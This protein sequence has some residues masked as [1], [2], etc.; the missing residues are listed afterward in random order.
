MT[1]ELG[2]TRKVAKKLIQQGWKVVPIKKRE[3][4]PRIKEWQN[5]EIKIDDVDEKFHDDITN[6]GILTSPDYFVIDLDMNPWGKLDWKTKT[7]YPWGEVEWDELSESEQKSHKEHKLLYDYEQK[8]GNTNHYDKGNASSLNTYQRWLDEYNNGKPLNTPTSRTGSL[9][10]Q[11]FV[12]LPQGVNLTQSSK[13]I[14]PSID[15]R[16]TGGQVVVSP[17]IHPNGNKYT[18]IIPPDVPIIDCPKWLL[19]KLQ[20]P[21]WRYEF[22]DIDSMIDTWWE[23][24][25]KGSAAKEIAD[26]TSIIGSGSGRKR[27]LCSIAGYWSNKGYSGEDL[28]KKVLP[29]LDRLE[30]DPSDP[31]DEKRVISI[32]RWVDNKNAGKNLKSAKSEAT[33]CLDNLLSSCKEFPLDALP[34]VVQKYVKNKFQQLG[35][36]YDFLGGGILT[37]FS[38]AIGTTYGIQLKDSWKEPAILWH[39]VLAETGSRKTACFKA[40]WEI[41]KDK[42]SKVNEHNRLLEKMFLKEKLLYEKKITQFKDG[43]E[44]EPSD[45]PDPPRKRILKVSDATYESLCHI[46]SANSTGTSVFRAEILGWIEGSSQYS[47]SKIGPRT[48]YLESYDGDSYTMTRVGTGETYIHRNHINIWGFSQV[49]NFY[50]MLSSESNIEDGFAP[51]FLISNPGPC[52]LSSMD[53]ANDTESLEILKSIYS[54]LID[55]EPQYQ[56]NKKLNPMTEY[57]RFDDKAQQVWDKFH[58]DYE[59]I[60]NNLFVGK[61]HQ[62]MPWWHKYPGQLARLILVIH[63]IRFKTGETSHLEID[64]KSI[65]MGQ[66]LGKYFLA[67]AY[68]TLNSRVQE[69][70]ESVS[71]P[72]QK[73][74][75][76][77]SRWIKRHKKPMD[78]RTMMGNRCF[79][80]I[81]DAKEVLVEWVEYGLGIFVNEEETLFVTLGYKE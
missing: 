71:I 32:C 31:V 51:R 66:K 10:M 44:N 37:M 29:H 49:K 40:V 3:K 42:E 81:S 63:I 36:P 50:R 6:I 64:S 43:N 48:F 35:V 58:N 7:K 12:R 45:P 74:Y 19:E 25:E 72:Y 61:N 15:T 39:V 69:S 78:V 62:F 52:P 41:A 47:K 59:Y 33:I 79:K 18:W 53:I 26:S 9:G 20:M 76:K 55:Y 68:K 67:N 77:I 17:S 22:R 75:E 11:I 2:Y 16:T 57:I 14:H 13:S 54:E 70:Q 30:N 4:F 8:Y 34:S 38:G 28:I 80:K 21:N 24:R 5:L 23:T 65:E 73:E 27:A 46:L 60:T 1:T 56:D